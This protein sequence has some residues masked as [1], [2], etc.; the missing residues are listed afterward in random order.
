ML[1]GIESGVNTEGL[2][3]HLIDNLNDLTALNKLREEVNAKVAEMSERRTL[4]ERAIVNKAKQLIEELP[5]WDSNGDPLEEKSGGMHIKVSKLPQG[6]ILTMLTGDPHNQI[7]EE[8]IQCVASESCL[9]SGS[10]DGRPTNYFETKIS[11]LYH[12]NTLR[13]NL[14]WDDDSINPGTSLEFSAD[15]D[16]T[17]DEILRRYPFYNPDDKWRDLE[18]A[19][20]VLAILE[21]ATSNQ[22][23]TLQFTAPSA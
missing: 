3:N 13:L 1:R 10:K 21:R 11:L 20:Q 8:I 17:V 7:S 22:A 15:G 2:R 19:I 23:T 16:D 12:K 9:Q 6:R 5:G 18:S 14:T 4:L